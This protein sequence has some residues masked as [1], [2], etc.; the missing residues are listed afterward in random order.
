[1]TVTFAQLGKYGR[2]G[3]ALFQIAA[4]IGYS[5]KYN[6]PFIFPKWSY[7]DKFSLPQDKFIDFSLLSY[8]NEYN[9]LRYLYDEMPFKKNCNLMGYFQSTK[10]FSHCEEDIRKYFSFNNSN[11]KFENICAI[12]VRHGDYIRYP[13]HHPIQKIDY[14]KKAINIMNCDKYIIFSDD[15]RWCRNNFIGDN[16]FINNS[17]SAEED[18]RLMSLCNHFIIANSSFSWWGAWLSKYENK[19]V[20]A[21]INWFGPALNKTNPITDLIPNDWILI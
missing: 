16:Y 2:L 10:Y 9:E 18:L 21:P 6:D 7:Q 11:E 14:Y 1:M 19:K 8:N 17:K 4:T 12:H 13:K 5:K 3:N 15:I 20:I